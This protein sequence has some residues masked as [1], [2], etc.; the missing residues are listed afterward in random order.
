MPASQPGPPGCPVPHTHDAQTTIHKMTHALPTALPHAQQHCPPQHART[1]PLTFHRHVMNAHSPLTSAFPLSFPLSLLISTPRIV[2]SPCVSSLPVCACRYPLLN[3]FSIASS[4]AAPRRDPPS[5]C[6]ALKSPAR[7]L[8]SLLA[9][10]QGRHRPRGGRARGAGSR[11]VG[12][13]RE[14]RRRWRRSRQ[15]RR[16]VSSFFLSRSRASEV[17]PQARRLPSCVQARRLPAS[18]SPCDVTRQHRTPHT[19][20]LQKFGSLS[21]PR[22]LSL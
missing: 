3:C 22:L 9:S 20:A 13:R 17:R 4:A 11:G 18:H 6:R 1:R 5:S 12:G 10:L 19:S 21:H 8:Q 7:A 15:R 14:R 16:G 2:S